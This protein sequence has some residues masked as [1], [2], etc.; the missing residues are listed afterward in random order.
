M[1]KINPL[2]LLLWTVRR[3]EK[4]VVHMYD[5]L[6]GLMRTATEGD[7]LNFGFWDD[8]ADSPLLAQRNLAAIFGKAAQ[9]APNQRIVDVGSGFC[10][11]AIMWHDQ[12]SP[13]E[14]TC[15]DINFEQLQGSG[16]IGERKD[17]KINFVNATARILPFEN[18]SVDR[19]LALESAQHFKPLGEFLLE[20][21]RILKKDGLL[22]MA[23]P[24]VQ[25]PASIIKLGI[26]AM[27]WSSEH[28]TVDFVKS[29]IAQQGFDVVS[30]KR[31]GSSVYEPLTDYYAKN[32]KLLKP[33]I[34][35]QYPSYVEKILFNSLHK[36]KKVS[37]DKIID[38]LLI[39]CKKQ[40]SNS[41]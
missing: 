31:I 41:D 40:E 18:E 30:M 38:Y 1:K 17:S 2:D 39:V 15:I 6:S 32:R 22:A 14:I 27:T 21:F 10:S 26:L 25:K 19:V 9:L 35:E 37:E 13:I 16:A 12:Y 34:L 20:S 29:V 3:N 4:D 11:P 8:N 36:M 23:I 7:M 33:K 5:S 28:Y 24:V